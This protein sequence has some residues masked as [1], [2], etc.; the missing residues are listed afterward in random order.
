MDINAGKVLD[1]ITLDS[2]ARRSSRRSL[3]S[4]R[5]SGRR[6]SWPESVR[7]VQSLDPRRDALIGGGPRQ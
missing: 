1:G 6:A 3:P 5:A 2:S 4:P 7:G